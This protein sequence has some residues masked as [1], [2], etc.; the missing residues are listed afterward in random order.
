VLTYFCWHCYGENRSESGQCEHCQ[1][2][3]ASPQ[4]TTFEDRLIWALRHPLTERRMVAVR[5]IGT[6]RLTRA[7][8]ELRTLVSDQD[9]Y[10]AAAALEALV[11]MDGREAHHDLVDQLRRSGAAPVRAVARD[12]WLERQG[13]SGGPT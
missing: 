9:P 6:R 8:Q 3:I 12:L 4:G 11:E 7:R 13:Q 5:A 1:H 10:L 2:E